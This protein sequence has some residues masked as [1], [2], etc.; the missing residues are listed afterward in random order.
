MALK[1]AA[2][3]TFINAVA[4]LAFPK[5]LSMI[6][7]LKSR[8]TV[9]SSPHTSAN[10]P[11]FSVTSFPYCTAYVLAGS[12]SCKFSPDFCARCSPN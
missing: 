6:L 3:F 2:L 10:L 5:L 9:G 7:A 12:P 1:D 4:C 11:Q 8:L